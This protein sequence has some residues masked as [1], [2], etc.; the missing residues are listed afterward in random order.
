MKLYYLTMYFEAGYYTSQF[1]DWSHQLY[2]ESAYM[3]EYILREMNKCFSFDCR[4]INLVAKPDDYYIKGK[5]MFVD[6]VLYLD[7]PFSPEYFSYTHHEEKEQYLFKALTEGLKLLCEVKK[8]D[9]SVFQKALDSLYERNFFVDHYYMV[10]QSPDK[11]TVA[12]LYCVQTM[13]EAT[14]YMDF[15]VKRKLAQRKSCMVLEPDHL[16]HAL[17]IDHLNWKDSKTVQVVKFDNT[18]VSEVTMD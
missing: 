14:F 17:T 18:I 4:R 8:W 15:F 9:F 3:T 11:K 10:K 2:L 16:L 13:T 6:S 12:K 1:R 7:I 5:T